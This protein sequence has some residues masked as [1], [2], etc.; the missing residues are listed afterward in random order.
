MALDAGG[1]KAVAARERFT[2]EALVVLRSL[3]R[4]TVSTCNP[5]EFFRVWKVLRVHIGMAG[6]A[7]KPGMRRST[8]TGGVEG[9]WNSGFAFDAAAAFFVAGYTVV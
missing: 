7:F 3:V 5:G 6:G 4:V 8:E 2:V 9:R 1:C